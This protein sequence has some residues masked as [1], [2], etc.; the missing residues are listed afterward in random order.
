ML[1]LLWDWCMHVLL[2]LS[3][4]LLISLVL[5]LWSLVA[6]VC[7]LILLSLKFETPFLIV[8]EPKKFH[9][10]QNWIVNTKVGQNNGS[11]K[12]SI[13][14][15]T[16]PQLRP[17]KPFSSISFRTYQAT[18]GHKDPVF[19]LGISSTD[20]KLAHG[21]SNKI[22]HNGTPVNMGDFPRG[23]QKKI[24]IDRIVNHKSNPFAKFAKWYFLFDWGWY[25]VMH[26]NLWF[27]ELVSLGK[28]MP[29]KPCFVR[30][31]PVFPS[32]N[33]G[34][35]TWEYQLIHIGY[36]PDAITN[37]QTMIWHGGTCRKCV[38]TESKTQENTS[39]L[40]G[41]WKL[42]GPEPGMPGSVWSKIING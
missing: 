6:R 9:V 40:V 21:I 18:N 27:S 14:T 41:W 34:N 35:A 24:H 31:R 36:D 15:H 29:L 26:G 38:V 33:S 2:L 23:E 30:H 8:F 37:Q 7:I 22:L 5:L 10:T 16:R 3:L 39:W 1:S 13:L 32:T 25:A 4:I 17:Q 42:G 19:P 20:G 11:L 12:T 28:D